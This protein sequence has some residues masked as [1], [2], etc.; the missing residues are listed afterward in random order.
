MLIERASAD[1]FIDAYMAFLGTLVTAEEKR[2]KRPTQWLVL[3]RARY[4]EDR[5][6][7]S[8]YRATLRRPDAEMLEAIR[9]IRLNRWVYLKDTRAYSVLLPEDGSYAHGVLGLTERLRDIGQGETGSVIRTGVFPLNG[10]WVCDGLIE[11]LVWLGPNIRRD[12][13]S[14]YQRLRQEGKFSLGPAPV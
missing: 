1:R 3:G 10:R 14:I 6:S 2:G 11:G 13:T 4:E 9:L 12:V 5:D 8:R 7:L